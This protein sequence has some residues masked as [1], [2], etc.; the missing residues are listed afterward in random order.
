M[1]LR[2]TGTSITQADADFVETWESVTDVQNYVIRL[3]V[4]GDEAPELIENRQ[5]FFITTQ[6]RMITQNKIKEKS[7]DPFT[8]GSFRPLVV[9]D[10]I[11][12]ETNPNAL[13]DDDILRI[14]AAS[15]VAWDE[16]MKVIDSEATLR[17]MLEVAESLED[18]SLKRFREVE[19]RLEEI[20]PSGRRIVQKDQELYDSMGP[21]GGDP[22]SSKLPKPKTGRDRLRM[23]S[24]KAT[25]HTARG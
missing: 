2:Q 1:A 17:R 13:N 25:T 12:I 6:E 22:N 19:A 20:H 21:V 18:V 24:S 5:Q 4:R 23:N 16:Y 15:A 7:L 9:P 11:T 10:T 8:N 3:D 14:F